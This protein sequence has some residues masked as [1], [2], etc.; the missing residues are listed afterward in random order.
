MKFLM[1]LKKLGLSMK[2]INMLIS[3][4]LG[5]EIYRPIQVEILGAIERYMQQSI[6]II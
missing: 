5:D 2:Q 1:L 6:K 3:T 4:L